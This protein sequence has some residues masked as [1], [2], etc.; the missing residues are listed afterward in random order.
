[1]KNL[2]F[3]FLL[4]VLSLGVVSCGNKD[5]DSKAGLSSDPYRIQTTVGYIDFAVQNGRLF[6]VGNTSYQI[7]DQNNAMAQAYNTA[8]N[9]GII[10][11]N[12]SRYKAT[13]SG[14]FSNGQV[15]NQQ[16]GSPNQQLPQGP[17]VTVNSA[18]FAR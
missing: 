8:Q 13:I 15:V 10:V 17:S 1:M 6:Q 11:Q 5:K 4:I 9:N 14:Y 2:S 16:Q 3:L 7:V 12:I 18:V